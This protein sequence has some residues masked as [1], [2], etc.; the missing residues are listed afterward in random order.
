MRNIY[1]SYNSIDEQFVT[2]LSDALI[3][4]NMAVRAVSE[5]HPIHHTLVGV[6]HVTDV[7]ILVLSPEALDTPEIQS[8]WQLAAQHNLPIIPVICHPT[9]ALELAMLDYTVTFHNRAF[10]FA[11][12][13]L[14]NILARRG[15]RVAPPA[16]R[17]AS[18]RRQF[19]DLPPYGYGSPAASLSSE[20]GILQFA[21]TVLL[22]SIALSILLVVVMENLAF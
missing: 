1:I 5:H 6:S 20:N 19:P 21:F 18:A 8:D 9:P 3:S 16:Y 2:K 22:S 4:N 7:V 13:R 12:E 10:W 17:L 14:L 15:V 11:F